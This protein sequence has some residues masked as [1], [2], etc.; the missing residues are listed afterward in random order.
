MWILKCNAGIILCCLLVCVQHFILFVSTD[1]HTQISLVV[2][3]RGITLIPGNEAIS[4]VT[5]TNC[6]SEKLHMFMF[7]SLYN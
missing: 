6:M 1:C 5:S 7:L 3:E 4:S 2:W